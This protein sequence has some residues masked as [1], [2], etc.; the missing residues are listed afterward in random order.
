MITPRSSRTFFE[1]LELAGLEPPASHAEIGECFLA[2]LV[3][4][5]D[6]ELVGSDV[7]YRRIFEGAPDVGR[8]AAEKE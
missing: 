5:V 6:H 7:W 1:A 3:A 4:G 8:P 2:L